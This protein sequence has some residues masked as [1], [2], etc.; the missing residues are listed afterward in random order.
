MAI[1]WNLALRPSS[2]D[3][4][5]AQGLQIGAQMRQRREQEDQRNALSAYAIDPANP[6]NFNALAM[7]APQ[8]AMQVQGQRQEAAA[9]ARERDVRTRAAAGDPAALAELAGIDTNAWRGLNSDQQAAEARNTQIIG[10]AAQYI[11]TLPPEA[12]AAAWDEQVGI[13]SQTN[14]ALGQ[15]RGQYSEA[16]LQAVIAR[17]GAFDEFYRRSQPDTFNITAGGSVFGRDASGNVFPIVVPNYN[18]APA[19]APAPQAGGQGGVPSGSPLSQPAPQ[20][21][22]QSP[23]FDAGQWREYQRAMPGSLP[24]IVERDRPVIVNSQGVQVQTD[25]IN[26]QIAYLVNGIWYDNPEGQ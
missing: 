16:T 24:A 17:A 25:V 26:G 11:A 15:Y 21:T 1:D 13:L 12:R 2:S 8:I 10:Q 9:A 4:A 18:G 22:R 20:Q 19:G 23:I 6:K 7:A 14:P 5:L 3:N